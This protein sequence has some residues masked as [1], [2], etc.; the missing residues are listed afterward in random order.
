MHERV[1]S[2]IGAAELGA[3][4]GL[5]IFVGEAARG[6]VCNR[7][8]DTDDVVERDQLAQFERGVDCSVA[9]PPARISLEPVAHLGEIVATAEIGERFERPF[10]HEPFEVTAAAF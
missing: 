5:R 6:K 10:L 2:K 8:V 7:D 1:G 4:L 3:L 9:E